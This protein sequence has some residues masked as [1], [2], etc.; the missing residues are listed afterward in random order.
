MKAPITI[1]LLA[2]ALGGCG[3]LDDS[4]PDSSTDA[5]L[6]APVGCTYVTY[7]GSTAFCPH[8]QR[9]CPSRDACNK[10]ACVDASYSLGL[11]CTTLNCPTM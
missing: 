8:G 6:D 2:L 11:N 4:S 1:G 7:D 10:C 5:G 3:K 9:G